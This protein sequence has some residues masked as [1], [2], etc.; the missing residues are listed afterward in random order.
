MFFISIVMILITGCNRSNV[1]TPNNSDPIWGFGNNSDKKGNAFHSNKDKIADVNSYTYIDH[2]SF[3]ASVSGSDQNVY[4]MNFQEEAYRQ[5]NEQK[6][7]K[8]FTIDHPLMI[9]NPFGTNYSSIYLYL[10]SQEQ[11]F[12]VYYTISVADENIPD[13]S[14]TMYINYTTSNE[15]EGQMVGL[16]P[17]QQNKIV[18][19]IR[20]DVGSRI[21]K[22]AYL[23]DV[24]ANNSNVVQRLSVEVMPEAEYTRGFFQYLQKGAKGTFYVFYDNYGILRGNIPCDVKQIGAKLLPTG[25]QLFVECSDNVFALMSHIGNVISIY[26]YKDGGEVI[27]YDYDEINNI[28]VMIVKPSEDVSDKIVMLNL[29]NGEWKENT[30]FAKLLPEYEHLTLQNI[31]VMDGKDLIV[32]LKD[33]N[34]V[35]RINNVYTN[36]VIRWMIGPETIWKD[37]DY[38]SLLLSENGK[39]TKWQEIDSMTAMSSK[40]LKEGQFYLNLI[41]RDETG[42]A[43]FTSNFYQYVVDENLNRYRV[44]KTL[45]Y[46]ETTK[47]SNGFI[48]GTHVIIGRSGEILLEYNNKGEIMLRIQLPNNNSSYQFYKYTMDRYWF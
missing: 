22:K 18:I 44:V 15:L 10:G 34:S 7:S 8:V 46:T 2:D 23:I 12:I 4:R 38:E 1:E 24:P 20:N 27:D 41:S 45:N 43:Q 6:K 14:E 33:L 39:I 21:T 35:I 32:H 16:V 37:T 40:K 29:A 13:F 30:D 28:V 19:D 17:G 42:A 48:Y 9:Y 11:K 47:E 31:Q 25:N 36:P 5:I 26:S 3:V